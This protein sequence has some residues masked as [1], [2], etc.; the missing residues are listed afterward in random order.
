M[1]A[2]ALSRPARWA[3]HATCLLVFAGLTSS[4]VALAHL[5]LT[6]QSLHDALASIAEG[7]A[8]IP[9]AGFERGDPEA[10][11]RVGEAGWALAD[12]MNEEVRVHGLGQQALMTEAIE[13]ARE[14]GVSIAWSDDHQRFF[15]DGDAYRRYLEADAAGTFA[16]DSRYRLIELDFYLAASDSISALR[17]RA[18]EKRSFLD[19][20]PAFAA[21]ARVGIFLGI[22]YR[23]LYR[24]CTGNGD[25]DGDCG[26]LYGDLALQAFRQVAETHADSDSGEVARR[27]LQRTSDEI[28]AGQ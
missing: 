20:Y 27:L 6:E 16:A 14:Y 15:Y 9:A 24:L 7:Y 19:D 17:A 23:D 18:D 21:A 2:G 22:D 26:Q 10:W 1:M 13:R 8:R 4:T 3:S 12:L 28:T 5:F 11:F 25:S